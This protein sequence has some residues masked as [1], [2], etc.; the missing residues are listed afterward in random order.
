[1]EAKDD[2][3]SSL[4]TAEKFSGAAVRRLFSLK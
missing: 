3:L 2:M 4:E 1:M